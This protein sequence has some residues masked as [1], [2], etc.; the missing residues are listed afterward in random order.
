MADEE[1]AVLF[2]C[3]PN[4]LGGGAAGQGHA[5]AFLRWIAY[6]DAV[7]GGVDG[8]K[9]FVIELH[10]FYDFFVVMVKTSFFFF[11]CKTLLIITSSPTNCL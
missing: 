8:V 10:G 1:V 3:L 5:C 2:G 7:A 4:H 9:I 11:R 6:D